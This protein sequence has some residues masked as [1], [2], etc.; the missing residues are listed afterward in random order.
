MKNTL[1]IFLFIFFLSQWAGAEEFAVMKIRFPNDKD[2]K[3]V[4]IKLNENDAPR[5]VENFKRLA[6][7]R[8]YNKLAFHRA[9]PGI[10]VQTGDPL[11]R[12]K[13]RSVVGTGGPG[14]TIP[15]E[16]KGRHRKGSVAMARLP[17]ETNPTR[18]SNGSQF[19]IT[20][21]PMPELDGEY[22]VFGEV[23]EGLDILDRISRV[24]VD[25]NDRPRQRY[26]I[27]SLKIL[28]SKDFASPES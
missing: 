14:Y 17:D 6:K 16:I 26:E 12:G 22:T 19:Y 5:T 11:S 24:S 10:M 27:R 18:R 9:F 20:L 8:F 21:K 7:K 25:S 4:I 13:D 28:S 1:C 2:L 15:G 23:I 3:R